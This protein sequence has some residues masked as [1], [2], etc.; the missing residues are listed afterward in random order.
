MSIPRKL[1]FSATE[2]IGSKNKEAIFEVIKT[3]EDEIANIKRDYGNT[4]VSLQTLSQKLSNANGE[5]THYVIKTAKAKHFD[6]V[7]ERQYE[8]TANLVNSMLVLI[9]TVRHKGVKQR[10]AMDALYKSA[11]ALRG[12]AN[13][14]E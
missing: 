5:L 12:F 7:L 14:L 8:D 1:L 9:E 11:S 10:E 4:L 3:L 13:A 6:S 2:A